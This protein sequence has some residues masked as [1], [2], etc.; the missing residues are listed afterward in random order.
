MPPVAA[1]LHD[2]R[3]V[4]QAIE[5]S[6]GEGLI[7]GQHFALANLGPLDMAI[8]RAVMISRGLWNARSASG[9]NQP[10]PPS[11]QKTPVPKAEIDLI[12]EGLPWE[13]V[14]YVLL[15]HET[16]LRCCE[17]ERLTLASIRQTMQHQ[18]HLLHVPETR[19][20]KARVIEISWE[21]ISWA[22]VVAVNKPSGRHIARLFNQR[23]RKLGLGDLRFSDLQR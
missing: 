2:V 19:T 1:D 14:N 10:M 17:M 21:A 11:R 9:D 13:A 5:H 8:P 3:L 6:G 12:A 4:Q 15:A 20:G 23:V 7:V 22:A 18:T 16:G